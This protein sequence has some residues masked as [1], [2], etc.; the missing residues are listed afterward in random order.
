MRT[1]IIYPHPTVIH[2]KSRPIRIGGQKFFL[3]QE[4]SIG[5]MFKYAYEQYGNRFVNKLGK[6]YNDFGQHY[7]AGF[8]EVFA[9]WYSHDGSEYKRNKRWPDGQYRL[10]SWKAASLSVSEFPRPEL[11]PDE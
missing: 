6:A 11:P 1:L 4:K 2:K 5:A 7:L 10:L 3:P 8:Y 9:I